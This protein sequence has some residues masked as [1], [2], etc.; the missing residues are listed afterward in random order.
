MYMLYFIFSG[1]NSFVA[2]IVCLADVII[3]EPL[4]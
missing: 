1:L 3:G 2:F 4:V